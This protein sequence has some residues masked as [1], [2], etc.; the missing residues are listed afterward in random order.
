MPNEEIDIDVIVEEEVLYVDVLVNE[1]D[2]YVEVVEENI[3][4]RVVEFAPFKKNLDGFSDLIN[5]SEHR[6]PYI[7]GVTVLTPAKSVIDV[8]T[9]IRND[10]S[11]YIESYINLINHILIIF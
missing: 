5:Q 9:E 1:E 4:E 10:K 6:L 11:V 7:R 8:Y 2:I 3:V